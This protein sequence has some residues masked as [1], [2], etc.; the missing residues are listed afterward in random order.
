MNKKTFVIGLL[1]VFCM[2]FSLSCRKPM[3]AKPPKPPTGTT[4][5]GLKPPGDKKDPFGQEKILGKEA[6]NDPAARTVINYFNF[7]RDKEYG[8]A[9]DLT[10]GKFRESKGTLGDFTARL[11]TALE[12]GRI[13]EKIEIMEVTSSV[14][15]MEK[16]IL[17][18][19]SVIENQKP[20]QL[21]GHYFVQ[22][23]DNSWKITES[24][25]E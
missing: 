12:K 5:P 23:K 6:E 8:K 9:Y 7:I 13:Y 22:N 25:S 20:M 14:S 15:G 16:M 10:T 2:G 21:T 1:L 24:V 3:T 18:S 4:Q 19:L 11:S 17:F